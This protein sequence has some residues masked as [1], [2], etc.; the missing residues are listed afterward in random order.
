MGMK[1]SVSHTR[2]PVPHFPRG[3]GLWGPQNPAGAG[4]RDPSSSLRAQGWREYRVDRTK[5][6]PVAV[7]LASQHLVKLAAADQLFLRNVGCL[8]RMWPLA[9]GGDCAVGGPGIRYA[10]LRAL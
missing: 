10:S 4:S 2:M 7:F 1:C 5:Q 8:S 3:L 6:K 9:G